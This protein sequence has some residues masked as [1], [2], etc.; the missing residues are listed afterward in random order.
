M[1]SGKQIRAAR[2][3]V[4]WD[5]EDLAV[6]TGLTRET[7]FNIERGV[8][9]PRVAT[10]EKIVRAFSDHRIE[11]LDNQGVRFR[12]EDVE[13]LN[14]A[15]G[16]EKFSDLIF[17]FAKTTGGVIRQIGIEEASFGKY[18]P[19]VAA[20][21]RKRMLE[22]VRAVKNVQVRA[23]LKH[24]DKNFENSDYAEFKWFPQNIPSPI[25][26]YVFGD[27]VCIFAFEADPPPKIILITSPAISKTYATQFDEIWSLA[28]HA[29]K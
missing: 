13:V 8:F 12:P 3:L 2:M 10:L 16:I 17:A 9:R 27:T 22:L 6:K 14:G 19:V 23:I 7:I 21:H 4:E 29:H 1:I 26:Y 11:F 15:Y 25:P 18:A 20:A 28:N 24:G 5:A